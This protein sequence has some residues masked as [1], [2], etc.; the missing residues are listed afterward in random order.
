MTI[1]AGGTMEPL[2]E[3]MAI[4]SKWKERTLVEKY[5][6]VVKPHQCNIYM[7]K[8]CKAKEILFNHQTS[9]QQQA[10]LHFKPICVSILDKVISNT[11]PGSGI[12]IFIQNYQLL[13][14]FENIF[15]G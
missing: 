13:A 15:K 5:P 7:I 9:N 8:S 11:E 3:L 2:D 4:C 14:M 1:I 6:H 12:V 10:H